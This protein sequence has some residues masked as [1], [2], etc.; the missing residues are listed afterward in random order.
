MILRSSGLP[1]VETRSPE[2]VVA[3]GDDARPAEATDDGKLRT[4]A[5]CSDDSRYSSSSSTRDLLEHNAAEEA[6]NETE[7]QGIVGCVKEIDVSV[8]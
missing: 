1:L 8:V 4:S 5:V 6:E 3:A 2:H 7:T